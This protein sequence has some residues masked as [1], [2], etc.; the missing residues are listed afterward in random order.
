MILG[1]SLMCIVFGKNVFFVFHTSSK[2]AGQCSVAIGTT[3]VN[4]M[5][6]E[7]VCENLA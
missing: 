2:T 1:A 6:F 7:R 3:K 5:S 4:R